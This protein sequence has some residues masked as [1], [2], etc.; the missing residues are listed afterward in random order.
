MESR[1]EVLV[2]QVIFST[3]GKRAI[4]FPFVNTILRIHSQNIIVTFQTIYM[5]SIKV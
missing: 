4:L 3:P 2:L 5:F 1:W